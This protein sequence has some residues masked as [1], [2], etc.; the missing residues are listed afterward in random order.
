MTMSGELEIPLPIVPC[1]K[2]Q[3]KCSL[4]CSKDRKEVRRQTFH[5]C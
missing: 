4:L 1:V 3:R 5:E 2:G